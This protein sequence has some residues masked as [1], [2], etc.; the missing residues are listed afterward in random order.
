VNYAV[1]V[2]NDSFS[3]AAR[4]LTRNDKSGVDMLNQVVIVG[5]KFSNFVRSVMLCCEEKGIGY[6]AGMEVRGVAIEYKSDEHFALHPSGKFPVLCHD[7]N[8]RA[9][10]LF[11]TGPICRYLDMM[12]EGVSLQPADIAM[13]MQVDQ[14]TQ[15]ISIEADK[16]IMRDYMLEFKSP[17]G[18]NGAINVARLQAAT[19]AIEHV[20][21]VLEKTLGDKPFLCSDR[22]T[23]ADALLTPMLDYLANTPTADQLLPQQSELRAYIER[24]RQ[25]PS[26]QTVL[27]NVTL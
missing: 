4:P 7:V 19:P 27:V 25:R 1:V 22:Y 2:I 20:L 8:D 12:F 3:W 17:T 6:T 9:Y 14:W 16:A 10:T 24:M 21:S 26:G 15:Y 11:E 13:R 5:P 18:D 23:T